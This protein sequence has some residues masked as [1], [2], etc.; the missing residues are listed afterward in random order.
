MAGTKA[1]GEAAARKN[2]AR[3]PL[4]YQ[5][6][7]HAGGVARVAKGFSAMEPAQ[8]SKLAQQGGMTKHKK[9]SG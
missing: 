2:K 6:I 1:G 5:K 4:H 7:G 9:K 3:D 8:R